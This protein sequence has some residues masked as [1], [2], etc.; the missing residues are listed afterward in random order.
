MRLGVCETVASLCPLRFQLTLASLLSVFLQ[1]G[2][3]HRG[4]A[5]AGRLATCQPLFPFF[6]SS[7]FFLSSKNQI[8]PFLRRAWPA[9]GIRSKRGAEEKKTTENRNARGRFLPCKSKANSGPRP[10][11]NPNDLTIPQIKFSNCKLSKPRGYARIPPVSA[12]RD[13]VVGYYV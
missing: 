6:S 1:V 7:I 9:R 4:A 2:K 12:Q 10:S 3:W 8:S 5:K 11:Q 13:T